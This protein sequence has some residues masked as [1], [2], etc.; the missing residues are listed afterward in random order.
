[1]CYY[2]M[3]IHPIN[4]V[5]DLTE[6]KSVNLNDTKTF[7]IYLQECPNLHHALTQESEGLQYLLN[8]L[9]D[10]EKSE[11]YV[12]K[13]WLEIIFCQAIQ[14]LISNSIVNRIVRYET[15][16]TISSRDEYLPSTT[17]NSL[18]NYQTFSE[19]SNWDE[20]ISS[21]SLILECNK[22]VNAYLDLLSNNSMGNEL[23]YDKQKKYFSA[24]FF[25]S[26]ILA[27]HSPKSNSLQAL[28][29][30]EYGLDFS[31][32]WL[33]RKVFL[34]LHDSLGLAPFL[35]YQEVVRGGLIYYLV[36]SG[37]LSSA[38]KEMLKENV[39]QRLLE[40]GY[41]GKYTR[42]QPYFPEPLIMEYLA[43]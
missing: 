11:I 6:G 35:P 21:P 7:G 41:D 36:M 28:I 42:Y 5:A 4:M 14:T 30:S 16:R 22:L 40:F 3:E 24:A 9:D 23:K 17:I 25:A 13:L 32:L 43:K 10:V 39:Q 33:Q 38:E 20:I 8:M 26:I 1:M 29:V 19:K 31:G 18:F 34:L 2:C 37:K 15:K 12:Y 27:I